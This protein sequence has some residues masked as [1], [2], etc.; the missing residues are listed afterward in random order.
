MTNN[1]VWDSVG[2]VF[3]I[4]IIIW[5]SCCLCLTCI[6]PV[7]RSNNNLNTSNNNLNTS[8]NNLNTSNNNLNTSNN[9]LNTSN[10]I[11]DSNDPEAIYTKKR[12]HSEIDV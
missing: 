1:I 12:K 3:L 11:K 8:N 10:N 4:L 6:T 5:M 2:G 9:N 7:I